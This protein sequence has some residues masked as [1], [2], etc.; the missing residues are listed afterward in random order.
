MIALAEPLR[1]VI[2][3]CDGV[4][5]DSEGPSNHA[6]AAEITKLGWPMTFEQSSALFIGHRLADIPPVVEA[7]LGRPVPDGWVETLR[8]AL[9][10]TFDTVETMPGAAEAL[11]ATTAL[12]LPWRVASNS[13]HAEMEVKFDKTGLAPLVARR[14]HSAYDVP[15]GKPHPDVF[16]AAAA[17]EGVPPAACLVVEDSLPGVRA[18][19]AAGMAVIALAPFGDSHAL[20]SAGAHPIRSLDE[21]GPILKTLQHSPA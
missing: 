17:A 11:R 10:A 13:S 19:I 4:L 14:R 3:D 18:A 12:G 21:L 15:R 1:L 7:H 6:V 9:I 20:E 2:F 16:L 5:V 8:Q